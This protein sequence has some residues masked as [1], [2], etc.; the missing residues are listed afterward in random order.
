[1]NLN[2]PFQITGNESEAVLLGL[3]AS[4]YNQA[5]EDGT[6]SKLWMVADELGE[7]MNQRYGP[8]YQFNHGEIEIYADNYGNFMQ[9]HLS[10]KLIVSTHNERLFVPG[11]WM[12]EMQPFIRQAQAKREQREWE[13]D[14]KRRAELRKQLLA[15]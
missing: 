11:P 2:E 1:M 4:A 14:E 10:G 9:I 3:K 7:D 6:I 5:R 12:D 15:A 8:K 13:R